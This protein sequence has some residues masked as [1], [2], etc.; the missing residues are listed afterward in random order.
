VKL[1]TVDSLV[2]GYVLLASATALATAGDHSDFILSHLFHAG[3]ICVTLSVA[4]WVPRN[5]RFWPFVRHGYPVLLFGFL[6]LDNAPYISLFFDDWFD[7]MLIRFEASLFGVH[8]NQ[9]LARLDQTWLFELWM[10]GYFFYYLLAPVAVAVAIWKNQVELFRR[11]VVAACAAFFISYVMFWLFPLEGPRWA[12][13]TALPPLRG[14][15]FHTLVMSIQQGAI[16]GGCMPSSHTA[17]AWVVTYYIHRIDVRAGRAL[18]L[19]SL[20]LSVGCVWGRFHY[21]TDVAVGMLISLVV[22]WLTE[23]YKHAGAFAP[24]A[25]TAAAIAEEVA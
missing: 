22:V 11:M 7:P 20:L 10:L 4:Y 8:P 6:Y 15:V 18:I 16:H 13:A 24:G 3:T 12:M 9:V 19:I 23:R 1:E 14:G 5:G 17:V 2:I 25:Q 21:V